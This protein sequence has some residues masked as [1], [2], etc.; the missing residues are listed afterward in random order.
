[1]QQEGKRYQWCE[2]GGQD[3][4]AGWRW[5]R[6]SPD[7]SRE[8]YVLVSCRH[9]GSRGGDGHVRLADDSPQHSICRHRVVLGNLY[10]QQPQPQQKN[11][12]RI[13]AR[14]LLEYVNLIVWVGSV[15]EMLPSV[16]FAEYTVLTFLI[17]REKC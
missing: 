17:L 2:R 8:V 12:C 3:E 1:M 4:D 7:C 11:Y 15:N 9:D 16:K 10:H 5:S 13:Y 14:A 6:W